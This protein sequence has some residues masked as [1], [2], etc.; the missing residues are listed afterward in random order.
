MSKA[1]SDVIIYKKDSL[2]LEPPERYGSVLIAQIA[3]ITARLGWTV[4]PHVQFCHE[5]VLILEGEAIMACNTERINLSAGQMVLI[6]EGWIHDVRYVSPVHTRMLL[7]GI[8][9]HEEADAN[10]RTFIA[11]SDV[12]E[13]VR[14]VDYAPNTRMLMEMLVEEF[15]DRDAQSGQ[16]LG[17]LLNALMVQVVRQYTGVSKDVLDTF[18]IPNSADMLTMQLCEYI[19]DHAVEMT[20]LEELSQAFSYSY[21]YLSHHFKREAGCSIKDYWDHHRFKHVLQ[22]MR[23]PTLSITQIAERVHYQSIHTFSRSFRTRFGMSPTD[24]RRTLTS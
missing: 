11:Q 15:F 8:R 17:S 20:S 1:Q 3:D 16:M 18:H 23:D 22:L 14:V 2:G 13:G 7:L 21:S 6:P 5:L 12:E 24:Y 4:E 9:L 19:R 10:L